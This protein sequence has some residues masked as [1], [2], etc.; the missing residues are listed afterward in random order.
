MLNFG[1]KM[2]FLS[3]IVKYL[4]FSIIM[5][6]DLKQPMCIFAKYKYKT[7]NKLNTSHYVFT[8]R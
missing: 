2:Q 3:S 6:R 4:S 7:N 5:Y 1:N 8:I